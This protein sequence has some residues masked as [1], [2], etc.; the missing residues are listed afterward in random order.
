M[1][2]R[3]RIVDESYTTKT[4]SVTGEVIEIGSADKITSQ[5]ITLDRDI[6]GAR[7]IYIKICALQQT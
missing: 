2:T 3:L 4:H 7:G 6:N 5:N 1:G